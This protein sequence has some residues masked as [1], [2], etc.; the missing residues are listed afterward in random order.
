MSNGFLCVWEVQDGEQGDRYYQG[1]R[2]LG[3]D[4]DTKG[5]AGAPVLGARGRAG[6]DRRGNIDPRP[7]GGRSK[8]E[9]KKGYVKKTTRVAF[10]VC[11][12]GGESS[13]YRTSPFIFRKI[14]LFPLTSGGG[15]DTMVVTKKQ[16][17]KEASL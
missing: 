8:G 10:S 13:P 3:Q 16:T 14:F 6:A 1:N 2:Q 11:I 4:R 7:E 5:D 12:G 17:A 15:F 9:G